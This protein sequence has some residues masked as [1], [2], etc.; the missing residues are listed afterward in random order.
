MWC[1]TN[2]CANDGLI[3]LNKFVPYSADEFCNLFF[4]NILTLYMTLL[5]DTFSIL[6]TESQRPRVTLTDGCWRCCCLLVVV[7]QLGS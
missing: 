7:L 2:T 3:M 6:V 1:Y 4:I 5:H